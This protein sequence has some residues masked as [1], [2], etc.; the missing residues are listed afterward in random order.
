MFRHQ[1]AAVT[2]ALALVCAPAEGSAQKPVRTPKR[3]AATVAIVDNLPVSGVSF[4]VQRRPGR[5]PTDL[6]LLRPSATA[7]EFSD[8][9]RTLASARAADGDYPIEGATVRMRPHQN[10]QIARKDFAWTPGV[11]ARLRKAKPRTVDGVGT[12]RAVAIWLP[13]QHVRSNGSLLV[14]RSPK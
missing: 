7:A 9:I 14:P 4:V 12:V 13:K 11:L 8:A 3:V 10:S 6:I 1:V 2:A 5:T